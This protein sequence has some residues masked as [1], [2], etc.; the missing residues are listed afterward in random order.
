M[1]GVQTWQ[2][3]PLRTVTAVLVLVLPPGVCLDSKRQD[4]H[5][6]CLCMFRYLSS[7]SRAGD[8]YIDAKSLHGFRKP[9]KKLK[10]KIVIYS[11]CKKNYHLSLRSFFSHKLL[12]ICKFSQRFPK[13]APPKITIVRGCLARQIFHLWKYNHSYFLTNILFLTNSLCCST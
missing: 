3:S 6:L 2:K 5:Q 13:H 8:A 12:K 11:S 9:L 7:K 1:N 4:G 10:M